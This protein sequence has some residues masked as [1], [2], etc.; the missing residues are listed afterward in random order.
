MNHVKSRKVKWWYAWRKVSFVLMISSTLPNIVKTMSF[1]YHGFPGG[2]M[3]QENQ[4]AMTSIVES[5]SLLLS[6]IYHIFKR[7]PY[8]RYILLGFAAR[9]NLE[10]YFN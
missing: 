7:Q 9:Y 3:D 6:L 10:T 5:T 4:F 2:V 8:L 1:L